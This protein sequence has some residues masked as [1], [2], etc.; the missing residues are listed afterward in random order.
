MAPP[1]R[2]SPNFGSLPD[3]RSMISF[4]DLYA[5][6]KSART[7]LKGEYEKLQKKF[8]KL[9]KDHYLLLNRMTTKPVKRA[10]YHIGVQTKPKQFSIETQTSQDKIGTTSTESQ[11][12]EENIE[13]ST[14]TT[15]QGMTSEN[16]D[17][18][19]QTDVFDFTNKIKSPGLSQMSSAGA[20]LT[21]N[22]SP[23]SSK[24][25][26]VPLECE[27]CGFTLKYSMNIPSAPHQTVYKIGV[28]AK[29]EYR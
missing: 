8:S 27:N 5:A 21:K 25:V 19:T 4:A 2:K 29:K 28:S 26:N 11:T 1:D 23:P 18:A 15:I 16:I 9:Q 12:V 6:E 14:Q 7:K 10:Q 3:L 17:T 24:K 13:V 20:P 22:S